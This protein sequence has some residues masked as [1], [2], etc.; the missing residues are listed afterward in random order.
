MDGARR[1]PLEADTARYLGRSG[2]SYV[3]EAARTGERGRILRVTPDG[4]VTRLARAF[5]YPTRLSDDGQRLVSTRQRR[6]RTTTI[7]FRSAAT[8][9]RLAQRRFRGY[10][11]TLDVDASRVLLGGVRRTATWHPET[12]SVSVLT[13]HEGYRGDLGNDLVAVFTRP[14]LEGGC[15]RIL[16]V[17]TGRTVLN[18]CDEAV[19]AVNVDA[20]R[21]A[22][23]SSYTDGPIGLVTLRGIDGGILGRYRA[24]RTSF[25][26]SVDFETPT[27][28][29]LQ[30]MGARRT[31]T[32][33][34]T[35]TVCELAGRPLRYR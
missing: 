15:T 32:V 18:L 29:L 33:R 11:S 23:V 14:P 35:G 19:I 20:S 16:R 34:C 30:V 8:G 21:I 22:T 26:D 1:V 6:D 31:G 2:T 25:I 9:A 24:D 27:A 13:R 3:V 12:G 28:L 5:G 10:V 7:T 4:A 17:S